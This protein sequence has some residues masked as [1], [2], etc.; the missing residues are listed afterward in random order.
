M[1]KIIIRPSNPS[2]KVFTYRC[3]SY[4]I[5]QYNFIVFI[6]DRGTSRKIPLDRILEVI[7]NE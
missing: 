3:E 5:D 4:S 2:D 7:E 1:K 6:D